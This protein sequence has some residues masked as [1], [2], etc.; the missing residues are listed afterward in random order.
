MRIDDGHGAMMSLTS[1][2]MGFT[3]LLIIVVLLVVGFGVG[4]AVGRAR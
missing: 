4:Y 3:I 1:G 2:H